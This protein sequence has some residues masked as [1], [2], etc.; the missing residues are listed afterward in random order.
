MLPLRT[1]R[2]NVRGRDMVVILSLTVTLAGLAGSGVLAASRVSGGGPDCSRHPHNPRCARASTTGTTE[3]TAAGTTTSSAGTT[4]ST[5]TIASSS[6]SC[7]RSYTADSPWNTPIG[8]NPKTIDSTLTDILGSDT[9]SSQPLEYAYPVYEV[10]VDTPQ[11]RIYVR[12]VFSDV[13]DGGATLQKLRGGAY[14][15]VRVPDGARGSSGTDS[16]MIVLDPATGDEWGFWQAAKDADGNWSSTNGYHYNTRWSGVPPSGFGSRGAGVTYL[17][18]L[19]RPCEIAQ[20]AIDHALAFG[21]DYPRDSFVYPATKS[22]GKS[23]SGLDL[24]E[25]ARL[26]LDPSLTSETIASWGCTG[27]CLTIARAMQ[28]YGMYVVDNSGRDKVYAEDDV[29]ADWGGIVARNTVSS[30]PERY[31]R[32]VSSPLP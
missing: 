19:I 29:T 24:P 1:V 9:L 7:A 6:S 13:R 5:T 30:I 20:G 21:Y 28:T 25:G 2:R 10:G 23:T 4:T 15:T 26:Q 14:V 31:L 17:A 8:A 3:T 27:A 11:V 12:N 22:D 32:R 18:G 16:S